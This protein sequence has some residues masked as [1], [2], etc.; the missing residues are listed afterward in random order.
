MLS[1]F[2]GPKQ[3]SHLCYL[4]ALQERLKKKGLRLVHEIIKSLMRLKDKT[5]KERVHRL[6][7]SMLASSIFQW[8]LGLG[9]GSVFPT[10][11][12]RPSPQIRDHHTHALNPNHSRYQNR[13][14]T[15]SQRSWIS[16]QGQLR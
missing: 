10:G 1:T 13:K 6:A 8:K 4:P 3:Q 11:T 12:S 15:S 9:P 7:Q 5:R 14:I 2:W 16:G